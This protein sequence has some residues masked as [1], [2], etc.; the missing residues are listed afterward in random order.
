[1]KDRRWKQEVCVAHK[2]KSAAMA[3]DLVS[4]SDMCGLTLSH[5]LPTRAEC[6][7]K[8]DHV[9]DVLERSL[10]SVALSTKLSAPP[11]LSPLNND[12]NNIV[13]LLAHIENI[14]IWTAE[15]IRHSAPLSGSFSTTTSTIKRHH[16]VRS[17][18][19][20][21]LNKDNKRDT[22]PVLSARLIHLQ[23]QHTIMSV[24]TFCSPNFS[25]TTDSR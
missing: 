4:E 22:T 6:F 13:R 11:D 18:Y 16:E 1:M 10:G 24:C 19:L 20:V 15:P 2:R 3:G 12:S 5:R 25:I 14:D 17:R 23:L 7:V 8:P 21:A 9:T